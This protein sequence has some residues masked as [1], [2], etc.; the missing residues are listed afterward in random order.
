MKVLTGHLTATEKRHI[1]ALF[2]A[3]LMAGK[4]N[5]KMYFITENA[6]VYTVKVSQRDRGMMPVPGSPLRISVNT[7]T[8]IL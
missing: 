4:I 8:F 6:G 7:S 5:R 3:N 1:K 2:E